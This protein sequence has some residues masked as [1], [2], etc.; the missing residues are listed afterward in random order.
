MTL[1]SFENFNTSKLYL[2]STSIY[3]SVPSRSNNPIGK[4]V[5][6]TRSRSSKYVLTRT[7]CQTFPKLKTLIL[8][9]STIRNHKSIALSSSEKEIH[10]KISYTPK[11][12]K[13]NATA[14]NDYSAQRKKPLETSTHDARTS[15]SFGCT[16][17]HGRPRTREICRKIGVWSACVPF[18][19]REKLCCVQWY[20]RAC[21]RACVSK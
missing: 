5:L 10:S 20:V 3:S 1:L 2:L 19:N 9:S 17:R 21:E 12:Q 14:Q 18:R 13:Q 6:F 15:F 11:E 16:T 7:L 8:C 4:S